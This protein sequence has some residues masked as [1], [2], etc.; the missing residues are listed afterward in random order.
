LLTTGSYNIYLGHPGAAFDVGRIRLGTPEIHTSAFLAGV[1]GTGLTTGTPRAVYINSSGQLGYLSSSATVKHAIEAVGTRS[2]ALAHLRPVS[3]RYT[4]D[5][6]GPRQYGLLAEE[7]APVYPEV[8]LR[9]ETGQILGI[10]YP[11][12]IPLLVNELQT[13]KV[14]QAQEVAAMKAEQAQLHARNAEQQQAL[15][16]MKAEHQQELAQLKTEQ[17]RE[18]AALKTEQAQ[19]HV[20]NAAQAQE[21]TALKTQQDSLRAE[22]LQM[23]AT[24]APQTAALTER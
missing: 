18:M 7:V 14:E 4:D 11:Q 1:Y 6:T 8:V 12:L 10:D 3:F 9:S 13:V 15:S 2:Q 5:P 23:R 21:L 22:L 19:L 16:A 17:G 24:L 20:R